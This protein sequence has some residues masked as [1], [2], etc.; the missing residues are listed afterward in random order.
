MNLLKQVAEHLAFCGLGTIDADIFWGRLPDRPDACAA[1]ISQDSALPGETGEG[2]L[3]ILNRAETPE[4]A[5]AAACRIAGT[6]AEFDGFLA[7]DGAWARLRVITAAGD[8]GEDGKKRP[9]Y[10][11]EIGVRCCEE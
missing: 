9:V 11:T 7:G 8:Q 6:L 4:A 3:R 2:R 1:V 5:Y 10:A